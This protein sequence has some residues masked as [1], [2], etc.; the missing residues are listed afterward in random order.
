MHLTDAVHGDR[1]HLYRQPLTAQRLDLG[2]DVGIKSRRVS[3][4]NQMEGRRQLVE[5]I[6][7]LGQANIEQRRTVARPPGEQQVIVGHRVKLRIG[8]V[9][10]P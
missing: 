1:D 2:I 10:S 3:E 7:L 5:Q 8:V 6:A 4:A 9:V